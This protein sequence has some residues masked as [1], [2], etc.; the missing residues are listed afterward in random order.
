[1]SDFYRLQKKGEVEGDGVGVKQLPIHG[2]LKNYV[3]W[4]QR[5]N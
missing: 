5:N 2:P 4:V 3:S 1:M